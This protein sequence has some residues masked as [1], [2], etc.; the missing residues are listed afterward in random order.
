MA[1]TFF[2]RAQRGFS[3]VEILVATAIASMLVG[4]LVTIVHA[5]IFSAA[6]FDARLNARTAIDRLDERLQSDAASAWSVFVPGTDVLGANNTD[7]HELDFVTEDASH[8]TYWWA[9]TF[10]ASSKRVIVYAYAPGSKPI[11]GDTF[12]AI[13]ALSAQTHPITDLADS[14][15]DIHDPLFAGVSA[16]PVD[17]DFGW[18]PGAVGGN[19]LV[20]VEL[21][22]TGI[23]RTLLLASGTAPSHFT[24]I[25]NYTPAPAATPVEFSQ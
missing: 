9:Y 3:L 2:M 4:I 16:T 5:T 22:G 15:S 11:A 21:T 20:R 24:V 12:N 8:Q 13:D 14:A 6:H 1:L 10:D 7:G 17:V 18:K 23:D 19:H 25:V